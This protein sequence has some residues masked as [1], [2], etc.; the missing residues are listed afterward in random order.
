MIKATVIFILQMI[1]FLVISVPL[2]LI[3]LVTV[4]VLFEAKRLIYKNKS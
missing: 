2:A 4:N 1:Y 3:L